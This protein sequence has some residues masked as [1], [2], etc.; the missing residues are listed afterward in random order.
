MRGIGT[1]ISSAPLV[2][3]YQLP[4]FFFFFF[5][6]LNWLAALAACGNSGTRDGGRAEAVQMPCNY[7]IRRPDIPTFRWCHKHWR[8]RALWEPFPV[9]PRTLSCTQQLPTSVGWVNLLRKRHFFFR[10]HPQCFVTC[11]IFAEFAQLQNGAKYIKLK[12]SYT[13][14]SVDISVCSLP[15]VLARRREGKGRQSHTLP[16][17]EGW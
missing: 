8:T 1:Y 11:F 16:D 13:I 9:G 2:V 17:T 14:F 7:A 6:F 4:F 5:P 15:V 12:Y 3:W 10:L